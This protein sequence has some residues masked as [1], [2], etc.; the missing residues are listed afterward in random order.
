MSITTARCASIAL[1]SVL[2][3]GCTASSDAAV[4]LARCINLGAEQMRA[5]HGDRAQVECPARGGRT[6]TAALF[7]TAALVSV[8]DS[9]KASSLRQLGLP[10]DAIFYSGP[11]AQSVGHLVSLGPVYV[12]DGGYRDNRKY[13]RTSSLAPY[14]HVAAAMATTGNH[15]TVDLQRSG[16]AN[17]EIVRLR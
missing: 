4:D 8:P 14:V 2:A 12:Y 10:T 5:T 16:T 7:P 6:V 15:F 13:S 3:A 9:Q 17:I 11:D 1:L